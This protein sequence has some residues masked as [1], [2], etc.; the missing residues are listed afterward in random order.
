M[1]SLLRVQELFSSAGEREVNWTVSPPAQEAC[2]LPKE[3]QSILLM[4]K[5]WDQW[6]DGLQKC[7]LGAHCCHSLG[8]CCCRDHRRSLT[9]TSMTP[10]EKHVCS[11]VLES[12]FVSFTHGSVCGLHP[13]HAGYTYTY[14]I[15]LFSLQFALLQWLHV[16]TSAPSQKDGSACFSP[17]KLDSMEQDQI[18]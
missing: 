11:A 4:L 5:R 8:L 18:N 16:L 7:V 12:E 9:E 6:Q 3:I 1:F 10:S 15:C 2:S 13:K 14:G 17:M